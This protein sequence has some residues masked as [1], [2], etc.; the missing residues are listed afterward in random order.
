MI[1]DPY[2][3]LRVIDVSQGVAGP[4]CG[5]MLQQLGADVIKIEPL[6]GDWSRKMG[7][8]VNGLSALAVA[9]NRGKRSVAIDLRQ[10]DGLAIVQSLAESSDVFIHNFRPKAAEKLGIGYDSL[11]RQNTRLIHAS[12]AGYGTEGPLAH[13]PVTDSIAQAVSGLA[14]SNTQDGARPQPIKPYIADLTA[15]MYTAHAIGAA[16]YSREQTGNGGPIRVSLLA[17]LAALQNGMLI[18]S[19]W[20]TVLDDSGGS[21]ATAHAATVP[22]GVFQSA[23]GYVS[24][25]SLNDAMFWE[26][27]EL[28]ALA[29]W[30][31]D[32]RMSTSAGRLMHADEISRAV[33]DRLRQ[34]T[35]AHWAT[36]F[37]GRN[38]LFATLNDLDDFM[39][40]PRTVTQSL[41]RNLPLSAEE[42]VGLPGMAAN[43]TVPVAGLP[44]IAHVGSMPRAPFIGEHTRELMLEL[45]YSPVRIAELIQTGVLGCH[46]SQDEMHD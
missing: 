40:D 11:S 41:L 23:D 24:L 19:R 9:Y 43:A 1:Q 12:I 36:L 42:G 10:G 30:S 28:L 6:S 21:A 13:Y 2:A 16:L 18:E 35:S 5:Q 8:C 38:V 44:G 29:D 34:K 32:P 27:C 33:A 26:I 45:G 15:G 14:L 39:N 17:A 22:Q 31:V 20:Q 46:P 25:A 7:A 37:E 3:G 4:Y